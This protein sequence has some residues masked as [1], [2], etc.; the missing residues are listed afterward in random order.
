M[1]FSLYLLHIHVLCSL[2]IR[3]MPAA[4]KIVEGDETQVRFS[5]GFF[6]G[7]CIMAPLT[8]WAADV[9]TRAVDERSVRFARWVAGKALVS[10]E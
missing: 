6:L 4:M 1:G 3:V 10:G 9:F 8:F 7:S 2:V 5:I